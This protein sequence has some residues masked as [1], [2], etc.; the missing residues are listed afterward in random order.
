MKVRGTA[1]LHWPPAAK[2]GTTCRDRA[3]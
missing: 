3:I 1:R 2:A